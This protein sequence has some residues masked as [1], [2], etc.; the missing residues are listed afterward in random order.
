MQ[1]LSYK[2]IITGGP[3]FGKSSIISALENRGFLVFHEVSRQIISRQISE[4]GD[5]LPWRNHTAFHHTVW[6]QRL[7]QFEQA[8][9]L[10]FFDRGLPDSVAYLMADNIPVPK[11]HAN[12]PVLK[13]YYPTV[14]ITPPWPD[15]FHNDSERKESFDK[16]V[17]IHTQ[18]TNLYAQ[19]GYTCTEIPLGN[20][21]QRVDFVLKY[22]AEMQIPIVNTTSHAQHP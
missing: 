21:M 7:F 20:I 10:C 19:L 8:S 5:I 16:A 17:H 6:Q 3:G 13:S 12:S 22:L 2:I 18:L 1:A 14:F 15:I 9:G 11:Q 4:A